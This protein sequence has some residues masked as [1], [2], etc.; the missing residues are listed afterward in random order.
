MGAAHLNLPD[1]FNIAAAMIDAKIS[2]GRGDKA[3]VYFKERALSY[4][5]IQEMMN[6]T[7][8]ALKSLGVEMEDRVAILL[9]D[10][11]EWVASFFGAMKIGA[12]AV[13]ANTML[14]PKDYHYLLNDSRAKVI[15][16]SSDLMNSIAGVLNSLHY[17]QH[18]VVVGP[19]SGDQLSYDK[20]VAEAS[21][22]LDAAPTTQNDAAFWCYTSGSTGEP[23]GVVHLHHDLMYHGEFVGRQFLGIS[24]RDITF[25][26]GKLFF[27]FGTANMA[28]ALYGG[29]AHVLLPD[30]PTP[31]NVLATITH[32][33][34]TI[35]Y[36]VPTVFAS[37]LTMED[38]SEYDL[39]SI[40]LCISSGEHLPAGLY[41][42]FRERFGIELLDCFGSSEAMTLYLANKPGTVKPGSSGQPTPAAEVKI[43]DEQGEELPTGQA[44][45]L[46]V[47]VDSS[48]PGYWNEHD[49]TK[50]TM[51]GSWLR[52]RDLF[53]RDEDG[54][55]Y[56]VGRVDDMLEAGGIK[57][58]PAEIE[59]A[60][61]EHPA[62]VEAAVVGAT[63][64]HGIEKP[65]AFVSINNGYHPSPELAKELQQFVKDRIAPYKYPRWIEFVAE[66][67]KTGTGKIQRFKL[68]Q[69]SDPTG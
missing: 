39:S 56:Y 46:L 21:P 33:R 16:V 25:S 67:P 15:I 68:R 32:Y 40:R 36:G 62:V 26:V 11:P 44:G 38:I 42:Q 64:E 59:A 5:D 43:V 28:A 22:E 58:A 61:I 31:K 12:V 30:R 3:A 65:K 4:H 27:S 55:F 52:T 20:L 6:R 7:G 10:S 18:I 8:N 29:A 66:L 60:L 54:Y 37:I 19:A 47:S 49:K 14:R 24:D 23:K 69:L 9:P 53:R 48:S 34:P 63:D 13:P 57:V 35:F 50:E 2:E 1:R 45:E 17:L 41:H 51:N